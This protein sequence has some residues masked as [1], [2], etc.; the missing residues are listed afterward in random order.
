[1]M[2]DELKDGR[3]LKGIAKLLAFVQSEAAGPS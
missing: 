3:W 1:M 2:A